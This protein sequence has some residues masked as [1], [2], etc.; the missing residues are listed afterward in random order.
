MIRGG[1]SKGLSVQELGE[2][3]G[4]SNGVVIMTPPRDSKDA[5]ASLATMVSALKPKHKVLAV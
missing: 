5:Q 1:G 2:I 4:R 3:L